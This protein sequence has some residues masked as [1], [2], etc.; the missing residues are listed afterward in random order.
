MAKNE[1]PLIEAATALDG[2]LVRF[3]EATLAFSKLGL[4]SQK[5]LDRA[6]KMLNDLAAS[7][8]AMGEKVQLLVGAIN[9]VRDRQMAQVE[10]VKAKSVQIQERSAIFQGL[11]NQFQELGKGAGALNE[12]L[13]PGVEAGGNPIVDVQT[14]MTNLA[15]RAEALATIAKDQDF[16]DLARQA[17]GL[18]QQI[19]A[20]RNKLKQIETGTVS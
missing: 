8:G 1:S 18:R 11:L 7:E 14:E 13:K 3:E 12:K 16:D 5:N 20:A 19:L 17:D 9:S 4:N 15:T 2:E 6:T 10:A